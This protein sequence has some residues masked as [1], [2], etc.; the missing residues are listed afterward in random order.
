VDY[1]SLACSYVGKID[2]Q[3]GEADVLEPPT[4]GKDARRIGSDSRGRLWV[5]GW[6]AGQLAMFDPATGDSSEWRLPGDGP[7]PYA[8]NVDERDNVWLSDFGSN[9]IMRFDAAAQTFEDIPIPSP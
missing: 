7:G 4:P 1:A 6:N 2:V 3:T 5:S 8:V 9:A